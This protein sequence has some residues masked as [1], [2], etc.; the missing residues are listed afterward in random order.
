MKI[1]I[2]PGSAGALDGIC[3]RGGGAPRAIFGAARW[4]LSESYQ[5]EASIFMIMAHPFPHQTQRIKDSPFRRI[6]ALTVLLFVCLSAFSKPAEETWTEKTL[7]GLSLREKIAQLIQIRTTGKFL[8]RQSPEYQAIRAQIQQHHIGGVVLFAGNVYESAILLNELQ[9]ISRL[10]LLVSADF[11]R[12]AAFRIGDTTSF[13]WTMALGATGS[14]QLAYRQGL[15][16]AQESRSLGVHWIFAP[17]MDVNNNPDNPVIS[18]RSFGEDP[19]LVARL[20]SAFIRGAKKGGVLTT[21][22]HFPGHGDTAVDSHIGLPVVQSDMAHLRSIELAPFRSA[23]EAGVDSIMTAHLAVPLVTGEP[24]TPAT[25]SP[26]ILT[27]LLR[28]TLKFRGLVVTDALEMAGITNHYWCGQAAILAIQAGADV[29]L[30]PPDTAVAINEIERAVIRGDISEQRITQS[31]RKIL[32]IKYAL[33]L[34]KNRLVSINRIGD[35]VASTQ[36]TNLA[37]EIADHSITVVKDDRHLLPINVLNYPQVFSLVLTPDLESSPGATFQAEMRKR[38]PSVRTAWGNARISEELLATIDKAVAESD[39]IVCSTLV[40]LTSGQDATP[41]PE[42][43]QIIF[44]K[45]M[46]AQ[47]PLIWVALG[48]PYVFR[49]EPEIGTYLCTFSYSEG[50]QVAAAKALAGEIEITGRMPVSIPPYSKVGDGLHIPKSEMLLTPA[51]FEALGLPKNAFDKTRQILSTAINTGVIPGAELVIG[52]QGK[53]AW[54]LAIGRTGFG[55]NSTAVSSD[56]I[57]DLSSLAR[58]VSTGS[59][60]LLAAESGSLILAAP[61]KDYVPEFKTTGKTHIQ[62][63]LEALST[64]D[65]TDADGPAANSG[66]LETVISRVSGLSLDQYLARRLFEPL[67]MKSSQ[68]NPPKNFHGG[69]ASSEESR[70]DTWFCNAKDLAVF[71]QMILNRGIYDHRRYFSPEAVSKYTGSHGS[72]SKPLISDWIVR[73]FSASS[74]GRR[75]SGGSIIWIDP[76]KRLFIVFLTNGQRRSKEDKNIDEMQ[77][78]LSESIVAVIDRTRP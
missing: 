3:R 45:L 35:V 37:R 28:N 12:G 61:V 2:F 63:L 7:K 54:D 44:K 74:F 59:G 72:W 71:A 30:L 13:P 15:I 62:D 67:G 70:R 16:T 18:I 40:R 31:V 69:T 32:D 49:F 43:Q 47:K 48:N 21:A 19:D 38:F 56:T 20:G 52:Y 68:R 34:Q 57:Y 24:E 41:I 73:L 55:P 1:S 27:D 36:N 65:R 66:I 58:S 42:S 5:V 22:K 64:D 25:L 60:I 9:T 29:L 33:G 14:E 50:S 26:M 6:A 75:S 17:V 23:I 53:I 8:N 4:N 46:A 77:R 39:L 78:A 51:T 11:E 76:A 10:P